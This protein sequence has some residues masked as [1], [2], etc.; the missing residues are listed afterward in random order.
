[1]TQMLETPYEMNTNMILLSTE[2]KQTHKL[3]LK[4]VKIITHRRMHKSPG[5]S[6]IEMV[7]EHLEDLTRL[8]DTSKLAHTDCPGTQRTSSTSH[9]SSLLTA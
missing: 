2:H 8:G 7:E 4:P 3:M 6:L 1:M 5:Q 9:I